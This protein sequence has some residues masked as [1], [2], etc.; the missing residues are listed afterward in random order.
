MSGTAP[1]AARIAAFITRLRDAP[2]GGPVFNPWYQRDPG[3]DL[4][5][6]APTARRARLAAHLH[7]D[8]ELLL[9]GEAAGYQG[10]HVSGLAFTSE[11]LMLE[12]AIPRI[13]LDGRLSTRN[14]PWSEPSAT[15]VWGALTEIGLAPRAV[16][17]NCFAWH[18][19]RAGE[20]QSNRTPT[21]DEY[22]QGLPVLAAL[23]ALY[24]RA[25]VL[26]VGK[27]AAAGLATLGRSVVSLRHPS[28]GGASAFRAGLAAWARGRATP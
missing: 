18:P 17:W 10:A 2:S 21:R 11:R 22:H 12:G 23:C 26:A 15:T 3:T 5:P 27:G 8:A 1:S 20:L 6:H 24:P 16:L 13:R 4:D 19:H 14:R 9:I 28:M 7:C 25:H